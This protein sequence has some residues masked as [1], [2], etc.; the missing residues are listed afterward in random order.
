MLLIMVNETGALHILGS[1]RKW[2]GSNGICLIVPRRR[3]NFQAFTY[4]PGKLFVFFF[5][6][7]VSSRLLFCL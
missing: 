7:L 2:S 4:S 5:F 6:V 1:R 3:L